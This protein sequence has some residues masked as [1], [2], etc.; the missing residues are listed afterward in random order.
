MKTWQFFGLMSAIYIAPHKTNATNVILSAM[1]SI[2]FF[3]AAVLDK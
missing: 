1:F 3:V 2:A